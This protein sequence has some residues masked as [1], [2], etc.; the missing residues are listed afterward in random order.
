MKKLLFLFILAAIVYQVKAQQTQI[1]KPADSLKTNLFDQ[2][3]KAQPNFGMQFY[4]PQLNGN[5]L[6]S[7]LGTKNSAS[8][9]DHMPIAFL[10][11]NSKMPIAK[12]NSDDDKMVLKLGNG[13]NVIEIPPIAK[14]P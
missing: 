3:F 13:S 8:S 1:V 5:L 2:Y 6:L 7:S 12:V 9:V 14:T 11:G 4:K 10:Q